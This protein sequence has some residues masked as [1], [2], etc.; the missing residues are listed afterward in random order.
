[1]RGVSLGTFSVSECPK[2]GE[3]SFTARGWAAAEKA[4]KAKGLFGILSE[5][6]TPPVH[7]G[8]P[9]KVHA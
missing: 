8:R 7:L 6:S 9:A 2:C 1:M 5:E 3:Y 4:A